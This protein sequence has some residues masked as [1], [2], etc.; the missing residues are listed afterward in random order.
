MKIKKIML[1]MAL[2]LLPLILFTTYLSTLGYITAQDKV[3][4]EFNKG[5]VSSL[6]HED[7]DGQTKKDV[8]VENNGNVDIYLRADILIYFEDEEGRV[9]FEKPIEG[10][11]YQLT[12][13]SNWKKI[14]NR[15]YY[16]EAL[17]AD[18]ASSNLIETCTNLSNKK[19]VVEVVTQA[20]QANDTTALQEAWG[21]S[22]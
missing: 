18:E 4:N 8:Y 16:Q 3:E 2:A 12:L 1:M 10:V 17:S 19:L 6:L 22:N 7:F 13:G 5:E 15:Y 21:L 11:D 14:D 9:L 20:L